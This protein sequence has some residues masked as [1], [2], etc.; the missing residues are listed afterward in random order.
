MNRTFIRPYPMSSRW[1]PNAVPKYC[2]KP[3]N[4]HTHAY[5]AYAYGD[6]AYPC[7]VERHHEL[8]LSSLS[9]GIQQGLE[10]EITRRMLTHKSWDLSS[11]KDPI[12]PFGTLS[13]LSALRCE[14]VKVLMANFTVEE[15]WRWVARDILLDT[16]TSVLMPAEN[17]GPKLPP[18]G[19]N[20]AANLFALIVE[21]ELKGNSDI[22]TS[23]CFSIARLASFRLINQLV[24]RSDVIAASASAFIDKNESEYLQASIT[25][26]DATIP[27]LT[28]LFSERFARL[29]E[30]PYA[31]Q[32]HFM[33][34]MEIRKLPVIVLSSQGKLMLDIIIRISKATLVSYPGEKDLQRFVA[35]TLT[36]SAS[37]MRNLEASNLSDILLLF[38]EGMYERPHG[39]YDI[40]SCGNV[41]ENDIKNVAHQP[42]VM[43][44]VSCLSASASEPRTQKAIYE[45]GSSVMNP[46]LILL[47]VYKH[48][49]RLI[50]Y[51]NPHHQIA[52][53]LFRHDL[54]MFD[55]PSLNSSSVIFLF[56]QSSLFATTLTCTSVLPH[57]HILS[58]DILAASSCSCY[59]SVLPS[60]N[61]LDDSFVPAMYGFRGGKKR[62]QRK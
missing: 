38:L 36:L 62:V 56:Y 35:L 27:L 19:V 33:D 8:G 15:T 30:V 51:T 11:A 17:T 52:Y 41:W 34:S 45:M 53:I 60:S 49:S 55:S 6:S 59:L 10:G 12:C 39:I 3:G 13:L 9:F 26:I 44:S 1:F 29:H 31:I 43:Q 61:F 32:T 25:A 46:I 22:F 24:T 37:G 48:E 18:E 57:P 58:A 42:D 40:L 4:G 28:R 7:F 23:Y 2:L 14:V 5:W 20:A 16:W 54:L 50:G 21:S 47:K